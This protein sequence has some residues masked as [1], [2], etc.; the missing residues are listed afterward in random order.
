LFSKKVSTP[1]A[2]ANFSPV[3]KRSDYTG[4]PRVML[5]ITPKVL[6]NAFGVMK[7][8][9]VLYPRVETLGSN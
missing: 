1:K 5:R 4:K 9:L 7:P 2:F 8:T 6:A 3:L